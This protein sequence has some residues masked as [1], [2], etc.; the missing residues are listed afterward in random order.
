MF[1]PA[2]W[3]RERR[4]A[5]LAGLPLTPKTQVAI[6]KASEVCEIHGCRGEWNPDPDKPCHECVQGWELS[7]FFCDKITTLE[8]QLAECRLE[9]AQ[10]VAKA[11]GQA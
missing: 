4:Y 7:Q 3:H 5:G 2:L 10:M 6:V 11:A 8:R 1:D 9:L